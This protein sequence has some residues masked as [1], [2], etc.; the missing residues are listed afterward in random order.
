MICNWMVSQGIVMYHC[1]WHIPLELI[2]KLAQFTALLNIKLAVQR[3]LTPRVIEIYAAK[4]VFT[5]WK[6][7][8][9]EMK[10][11]AYK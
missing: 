5:W 8:V 3:F 2:Y 10:K 7:Y 11:Y 6:F 4:H 1:A 9:Q